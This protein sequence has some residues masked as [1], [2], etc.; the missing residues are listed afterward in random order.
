[1]SGPSARTVK[2][3]FA[4]SGNRCAFPGCKN[5]LFDQNGNLIA[6]V[7]HIAGDKPG[8]KRYDPSQTEEQRHGFD[9]LIVLCVNHHRVVDSDEGS[10]TRSM[11]REMKHAHESSATKEFVISDQQAEKIATF[12]GGALAATA[13]GEV[14]REVAGAIH[15]I[16]EAL[17]N[18]ESDSNK[19]KNAPAPELIN[20]LRYAPTGIFQVR[21]TDEPHR[22]L[23][24]FFVEVFNAAGW[25]IREGRFELGDA[26]S[27]PLL[28]LWFFLRD[29]HQVSNAQKAIWEVFERCGFVRDD[30]GTASRNSAGYLL[31]IH[32]IVTAYP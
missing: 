19:I 30:S 25:R 27:T 21:S 28:M 20:I 13:F 22:R 12:L 16:N 7:C 6:G 26:P 24:E 8:A 3:L 31:R 4:L 10:C 23:G 14:V 11:L 1:M 32:F 2:R 5:P 9:N 29:R 15:A 17:D 18:S